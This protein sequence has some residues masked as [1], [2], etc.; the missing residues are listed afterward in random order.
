MP[1]WIIILER[2]NEPSDMAFRYVLWAEV[3]ITRQAFYADPEATSAYKE[4]TAEELAAI[5]SGAV[6]EHCD[7][8]TYPKDMPLAQIL[9]DLER[10]WQIF[11]NQVSSYNPWLRYGSYWDGDSWTQKGVS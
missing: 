7:S 4:A 11:Q 10:Q 8:A 5:R 2:I 6:R 3:P 9:T 1:K